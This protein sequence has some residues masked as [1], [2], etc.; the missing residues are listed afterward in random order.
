MTGQGVFMA[1]ETLACD[2]LTM[3]QLAAPLP[4]RCATGNAYWFLTTP[5]GARRDKVR[6]FRT[7]IR[8]E[9]ERSVAEWRGGPEA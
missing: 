8:G 9:L 4:G 3:G 6:R 5:N 1:W 7:W 2:A